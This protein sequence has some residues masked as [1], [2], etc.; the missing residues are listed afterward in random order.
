[1]SGATDDFGEKYGIKL[2][3]RLLG[4]SVSFKILNIF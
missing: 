3:T 2:Y 1:M 4:I